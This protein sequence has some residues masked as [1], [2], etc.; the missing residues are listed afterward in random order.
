MISPPISLASTSNAAPGPASFTSRVSPPGSTSSA[1]ASKRELA[2][3]A[4]VSAEYGR[5]SVRVAAGLGKTLKVTSPITPKRPRL[6]TRNLGTSK[7]AAFLTTLPPRRS[8]RPMPS[9]KRTPRM[10]SRTPPKRKRPG[11]LKPEA[12][13]PTIVLPAATSM[14]SNGR[15]CPFSASAAMISRTGVPAS[16]VKVNSLGSYS[17][18]PLSCRVEI[19]TA[20]TAESLG[21]VSAPT[22]MTRGAESTASR[23]SVRVAGV[24]NCAGL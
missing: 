11:P 16:A 21:F 20:S 18:I 7:P 13:A 1:A 15:Y 24:I 6:P 14:G 19:F 2:M 8:R 10:K 22:A 4:I 12:T 17:V 5:D 23:S 9:M 3:R